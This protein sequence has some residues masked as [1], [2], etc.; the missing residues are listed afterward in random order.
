MTPLVLRLLHRNG[1][2]QSW[3]LDHRIDDD[4]HGR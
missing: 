3:I 4:F 1:N 2:P